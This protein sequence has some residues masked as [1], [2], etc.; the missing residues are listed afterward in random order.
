MWAFINSL[1]LVLHL[2]MNNVAFPEA[3]T[4]FITPL[5]KVVTFDVTEIL[6][7]IGLEVEVF[8]FT[9][10]DPFSENSDY[11]GYGS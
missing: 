5:I 8:N 9:E 7:L 6:E 10:T 1:Q 3:T 2:P 11:L 4:N